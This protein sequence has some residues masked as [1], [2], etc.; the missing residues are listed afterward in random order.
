MNEARILRGLSFH[1]FIIFKIF[2]YC[3]ISSLVSRQKPSKQHDYSHLTPI[4][5]TIQVRQKKNKVK[6]KDDILLW[7]HLRFPTNKICMNQLC[8]DTGYC[9]EPEQWSIGRERK[10]KSKGNLCCPYALMIIYNIYFLIPW[11]F[12]CTRF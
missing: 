11:G 5:H 7:I 9:W 4:T 8:A 12:H 3:Y 6:L 2:C 10:R 1:T